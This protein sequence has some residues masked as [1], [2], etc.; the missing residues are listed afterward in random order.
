MGT[1]LTR[2]HPIIDKGMLEFQPFGKEP[3]GTII[4]DLSGV[5]IGA[6]VE[7]LQDV[8]SRQKGVQAGRQVVEDLVRLLNERIPDRAYHVTAEFLRSPWNSYSNEFSAFV[9]QFCVNLS[10]DQEFHFSMAEDKAISPIILA[11]GRP[12]SISQIYKMSTY[13]A[14]RYSRN[15]FQVEPLR[16]ATRW[17]LLRLS[18][19]D[20]AYRHFD[21]YRRACVRLWCNAVR[22]YFYAVPAKFHDSSPAIVV[23][24]SCIAEGDESCEWEVTWQVKDSPRGL[25]PVLARLTS[26]RA[27]KLQEDQEQII[28]E[29][30]RS[31]DAWHDELQKAYGNQQQ[32]TADLQ[33]RVVE[34][35]LLHEMSFVSIS[36]LDREAL[37]QQVLEAIAQKLSYDRVMITF[38][39]ADRQMGYDIR[40][41]GVGTDVKAYARELEIP[42]TDPNSIEGRVLLKGEP[43]MMRDVKNHWAET[44]P[45][46]QNIAKMT[47]AQSLLAVPLRVKE[48]IIGS[49][50]VD[51]LHDVPLHQDDL[52]LLMTVGT[53]LGMALDNAHAYR[54]IE[55][56][57]TNL[58]AKVAER[59]AALEQFLAKVSHDLRTPL[60]SITGFTEN[61]LSGLGGG[62]TEKQQQSLQRVLANSQRLGRLID[63]LLDKLLDR[64][65]GKLALEAVNLP[66]LARE[67]VEQ[68]R[69][70]AIGKHQSLEFHAEDE[71][72][73]ISADPD[74]VTRILMN[75]IDNSIKYT[76]NHGR[77]LV[78][79][80]TEENQTARVSVIDTGEGMP[81]EIL[82]KIFDPAFHLSQPRKRHVP[83][84][85]LGLSIVKDLVE[86]HG[87]TI[88][89]HSEVGKGSTFTLTLPLR[90]TLEPPIQSV[91][92]MNKVKRLLVVDDDPD[93]RQMLTD[94]LTGSGYRVQTVGDGRKA[95]SLVRSEKFDGLILDIG[96]P[97][98]S[99]LEVLDKI[100][101]E[102]KMLPIIMITATEAHQRAHMAVRAG[103]Q[104]YLLK[105]FDARQLKEVVEQW[106][107]P[108]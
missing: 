24:R 70:L 30:A 88:Q 56:L 19:T 71:S 42:I 51:R 101:V 94:R 74:K 64:D 43:V 41:F 33:R 3:D 44:H 5:V 32:L 69:P 68:L 103:A 52:N 55:E 90:R 65:K 39:D 108:P 10:G 26:S 29:Q 96:M 1:L 37:I 84:H 82:P 11:L 106:V 80:A 58:E 93:I 100:R 77:V 63:E 99:G 54:Q 60:T 95:L 17:S 21:P 13:F 18:F 107:G 16:I 25:W 23:E 92:I 14:Q 38:Y 81:A 61:M 97:G 4:R 20:H 57:N 35:T 102:Q 22:G 105:P 62:L 49:L 7:H 86:R 15:S 66:A 75:L 31:L 83:S 91:A 89:V 98:L 48:R 27:P 59:T 34:L 40:L 76:P 73:I 6:N 50:T 28:E 9:G 104:A 79:V 2:N 87:G 53:Q 47:H 72:V 8:V 85:G 45:L 12:F 78:E 36:T 67:I 46:Y